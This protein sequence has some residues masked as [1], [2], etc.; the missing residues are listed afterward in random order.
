[1]TEI[2]PINMGELFDINKRFPIVLGRISFMKMFA[3]GK[4][5]NLGAYEGKMFGDKAVNV[6]LYDFGAKNL[7]IAN[8]ENLPFKDKEFDCAVISEVLEHVDDPVKALRE[9]MRVADSVAISVPNESEFSW[10]MKPFQNTG[11]GYEPTSS[12]HHVR[13]FNQDSL[14]SLFKEVNFP[15]IYFAKVNLGGWSALIA[16]GSSLQMVELGHRMAGTKTDPRE[17]QHTLLTHCESIALIPVE[18]YI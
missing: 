2:Q 4:V 15:L 6:D 5:I 16:F 17:G 12:G 3:Y 8:I 11:K 7:T 1:M 9:A 14:L 10:D 18:K 13:F